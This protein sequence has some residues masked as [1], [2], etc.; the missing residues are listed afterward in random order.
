MTAE[1]FI[2][3]DARYIPF[4]T[5]THAHIES[6]LHFLVTTKDFKLQ[7]IIL[8]ASHRR[9]DT[10]YGPR[11][12]RVIMSVSKDGPLRQQSF[13]LFFV[14]LDALL[15]VASDSQRWQVFSNPEAFLNTLCSE[16]SPEYEKKEG[17]VGIYTMNEY[18]ADIKRWAATNAAQPRPSRAPHAHNLKGFGRVLYDGSKGVQQSALN[19]LNKGNSQHRH[20][21][22]WQSWDAYSQ[23][24]SSSEVQTDHSERGDS[25]DAPGPETMAHGTHH[26]AAASEASAVSELE[27]PASKAK[28]PLND[29][30]TRAEHMATTSDHGMKGP[31]TEGVK[32]A[33]TQTLPDELSNDRQSSQRSP[34]ST[35]ESRK[36][37]RDD[38][39]YAKATSVQLI[40]H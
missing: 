13:R 38:E 2:L 12:P 11:E 20:D 40:S 25:A 19:R 5:S 14:Q 35:E 3:R 30:A 33:S 28:L 26:S 23:D 34:S 29:S 27:A 7:S 9:L 39:G 32:N 10:L 24:E 8:P 36:R 31:R 21:V 22:D 18:L 6:L 37:G 1:A 15:E 4:P 16:Y 17:G